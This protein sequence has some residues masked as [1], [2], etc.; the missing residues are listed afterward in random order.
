LHLNLLAP[1]IVEAI[2][3]GKQPKDLKMIDFLRKGVPLLWEEQ[4]EKF[5][6]R[7]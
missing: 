3:E 2:L 4:M 1:D 7:S 6:F 5:G